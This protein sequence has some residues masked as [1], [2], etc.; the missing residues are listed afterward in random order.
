MITQALNQSLPLLIPSQK[1]TMALNILGWLPR[2]EVPVGQCWRSSH[3][4]MA[5]NPCLSQKPPPEDPVTEDPVVSEHSKPSSPDE[6]IQWTPERSEHSKPSSPEMKPP[7]DRLDGTTPSS[8]KQQTYLTTHQVKF[9]KHAYGINLG[10]NFL[11]T[12][13]SESEVR[14]ALLAAIANMDSE[15]TKLKSSGISPWKLQRRIHAL[16]NWDIGIPHHDKT[17]CISVKDFRDA[18]IDCKDHRRQG[19]YVVE[20]FGK[21]QLWKRKTGALR[22]TKSNPNPVPPTDQG[23]R[24]LDCLDT[25]TA[26]KDVH[27]QI[28][29]HQGKDTSHLHVVAQG[30]G[31]I[32][33]SELDVFVKT[34]P[35]CCTQ[36]AETYV[37]KGAVKRIE[38][39]YFRARWVFDLISYIETPAPNEAGVVMQYMLVIKDHFD[40]L[41]MLWPI[42][43]KEARYVK[44]AMCY[45]CNL[46]GFPTILHCDN[47][48]EFKGE[49][50]SWVGEIQEVNTHSVF[51]ITGMTRTPRH[52]GS[53]ER[54]N[55]DVKKAVK[56]RVTA[57]LAKETDPEKRKKIHWVSQFP[58]VM[59]GLNG[60]GA[61]S[62][63]LQDK[64]SPYYA[65]F[66]M[67]F[68]TEELAGLTL[69][70]DNLR[71]KSQA[72]L[73]RLIGT[74]VQRVLKEHLTQEEYEELYSPNLGKEA[75]PKAPKVPV[76]EEA[77]NGDSKMPSTTKAPA[78]KLA[79]T[80][81]T[82]M[83]GKPLGKAKIATVNKSPLRK[84][85]DKG[86]AYVK[87]SLPKN[88]MPVKKPPTTAYIPG[89]KP[90]T[91]ASVPTNNSLVDKKG[92]AAGNQVWK[93]AG[94]QVQPVSTTKGLAQKSTTKGPSVKPASSTKSTTKGPSAKPV[95]TTKGQA[96]KPTKCSGVKASSAKLKFRPIPYDTDSDASS[97][98]RLQ[99]QAREWDTM[100]KKRDAA[101]A[102][103]AGKCDEVPNK[104]DYDEVPNKG[105]DDE[106]TSS[107]VSIISGLSEPS[108]NPDTTIEDGKV[109]VEPTAKRAK[110]VKKG[111]EV[112]ATGWIATDK[113]LRTVAHQF[114]DQLPKRRETAVR[115]LCDKCVHARKESTVVIFNEIYH[116]K[117]RD[118]KIWFPLELMTSF[119]AMIAHL[120]HANGVT[121]IQSSG[122]QDNGKAMILDLADC[123]ALRSGTHTVIST[124]LAEAHY[125]AIKID[126][127]SK[128][129]F[130]Y[131]GM[132]YP[133][134]TWA[135][136]IVRIM[137][138][139]LLIN[140][141]VGIPIVTLNPFYIAKHKV[142][143]VPG[144]PQ[145]DGWNC[146]PRSLDLIWEEISEGEHV[147]DP[148]KPLQAVRA[149]IMDKYH[150]LT[151][152]GL[153]KELWYQ[154]RQTDGG[155]VY[156]D[157]TRGEDRNFG[158]LFIE[159]G[160][161]GPPPPV[162]R[163]NTDLFDAET[164]KLIRNGCLEDV[165]DGVDGAVSP[166]WYSYSPPRPPGIRHTNQHNS[167]LLSKKRQDIQGVLME[168]WN[169]EQLGLQLGVVKLGDVVLV[170]VDPRDRSR[171]DPSRPLGVVFQIWETDNGGRNFGVVTEAGVLT[172]GS[173]TR[174]R[175]SHDKILRFKIEPGI[176]S[177]LHQ[178]KL[179]VD[180]GLFDVGAYPKISIRGAHEADVKHKTHGRNNCKCSKGCKGSCG[181][182]KMNVP[183]HS[184]CHCNSLGNCCNPCTG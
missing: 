61:K 47:G 25:F 129:I 111:G 133:I 121:Y 171:S 162:I 38:S 45:L 46:M 18:H 88:H 146:G 180:D 173:S 172:V 116:S 34:C 124:V 157:G 67:P 137:K 54:A 139:C 44:E 59:G 130:V 15:G 52:Q 99:I 55:R 183:C 118:S 161:P 143:H 79:T 142:E 74:D 48:S 117:Y 106:D 165:D 7:M 60:G 49:F 42:P 70:L 39:D 166:G 154:L 114:G 94:K 98:D 19:Y 167:D 31:N 95:F 179:L 69:S 68:I 6:F 1:L 108:N 83:P 151:T 181:C 92:L 175:L 17:K 58:Y 33:R 152:I 156:A 145:L 163:D 82:K 56:A 170:Q 97:F 177:A 125:A 10:P 100:D 168:G 53:V 120:Y 93:P 36:Q 40:R 105:D 72:E 35:F 113:Y 141:E 87:A 101:V 164:G 37:H 21:W 24:I 115:I 63:R 96:A 178:I 182:R 80:V 107:S 147:G 123:K 159:Q 89:R 127:A 64:D 2:C 20:S 144:F 112:L 150:Q 135:N 51:I 128:T 3:K 134:T 90:P 155:I 109:K 77:K 8:P 132:K 169:A 122:V 71:G 84:M 103:T 102:F 13:K 153:S 78:G 41:L 9:M 91:N 14:V 11:R 32:S 131:E 110:L 28:S 30:F 27:D 43:C 50:L 23:K 104:G 5:Q 16:K 26:I 140:P 76:G 176:S 136:Q 29:A 149:E 174:F 85:L 81:D 184:G 148:N 75:R 65:V 160:I 126:I 86:A 73:V 138:Q 22:P 158:G 12:P 4:P 62:R 66:G 57:E 119:C